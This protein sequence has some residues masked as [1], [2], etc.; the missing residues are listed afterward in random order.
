MTLPHFNHS[1]TRKEKRETERQ[2]ERQRDRLTD[3][4]D[5]SEDHDDQDD[6]PTHVLPPACIKPHGHM[7]KL[8]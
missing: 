7:N 2:T 3:N 5:D 4:A 6:P 1:P 8:F